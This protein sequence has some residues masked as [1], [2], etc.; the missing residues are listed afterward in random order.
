M[1]K[2][3]RFQKNSTTQYKGLN[4]SSIHLEALKLTNKVIMIN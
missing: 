3:T 4:D 1:V 2:I